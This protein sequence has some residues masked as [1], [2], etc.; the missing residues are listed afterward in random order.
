MPRASDTFV[1]QIKGLH[2]VGLRDPVIKAEEVAVCLAPV[3]S[4]FLH[5]FP[6][7]VQI[8]KLIT[9]T[10]GLA[11]SVLWTFVVDRREI[12]WQTS[13]VRQAEMPNTT[14]A[15]WHRKFP[16]TGDYSRLR[17]RA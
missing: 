3:T 5:R 16:E 13:P 14:L 6:E 12:K 4:Q 1:A 7:V 11:D 15:L 9:A 17:Y 8:P 2:T 10:S